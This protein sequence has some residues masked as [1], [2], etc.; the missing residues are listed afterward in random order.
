MVTSLVVS[1]VANVTP[2]R[3]PNSTN[4]QHWHSNPA[5]HPCP[6]F[7]N[8]N[9]KC[10]TTFGNCIL[11]TSFLECNLQGHNAKKNAIFSFHRFSLPFPP[12]SFFSFWDFASPLKEQFWLHNVMAISFRLYLMWSLRLQWCHT[13]L[14]TL[15]SYVHC[16]LRCGPLRSRAGTPHST[17]FALPFAMCIIFP[18]LSIQGCWILCDGPPSSSWSPPGLNCKL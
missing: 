13:A 1:M 2:L 12:C 15:P 8:T 18:H 17:F 7:E 16:M 4:K 5:I 10:P 11:E 3:A 6:D 14:S 9:W